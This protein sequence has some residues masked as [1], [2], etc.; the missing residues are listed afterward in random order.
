VVEGQT[1]VQ[2]AHGVA[3]RRAAVEQPVPPLGRSLIAD[4]RRPPGQAA[5]SEVAGEV[6]RHHVLGQVVHG[7]GEGRAD[8]RHQVDRSGGRRDH[9]HAVLALA[10][11]RPGRR[12]LLGADLDGL[13]TV[14]VQQQRR[15]PPARDG[16]VVGRGSGEHVGPDLVSHPRAV[17][18]AHRGGV[19]VESG[20]ELARGLRR[21]RGLGDPV[22]DAR[23]LQGADEKRPWVDPRHDRHGRQV[24]LVGE[25]EVH[26]P[27]AAGQAP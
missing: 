7:D 21:T 4:R 13:E 19:G 5:E 15:P 26:E 11:G 8:R 20:V 24:A 2:P 17:D 10:V 16:D 27:D 14:V 25:R 6:A 9:H 18:G 23:P 12:E 1:V 22:R 3:E